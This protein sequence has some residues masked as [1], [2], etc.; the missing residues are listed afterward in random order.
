MDFKIEP[1]Y[2][3]AYST[4]K[5]D[6]TPAGNAAML[7]A[8]EPDIDKAI[9]THVGK[10]NPLLKSQARKLAI[11]GMQ[12][13]DPSQSRIRTHLYNQLQ[14]LKRYNAKQQQTIKVPERIMLDRRGIDLLTTEL[15]DELGREPTDQELTDR[16]GLSDKRLKRIR[17][18][19]P[20]VNEGYLSSLP[21][22]GVSPGVQ[23]DSDIWMQAVYE[24]LGS[25]DQK[26]FEWTLGYNGRRPLSNQE[27]AKKLKLSPGA[28]SQ[29][30]VG[31]QRLIEM[32]ADLSPF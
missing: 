14:G 26:I 18:Y 31:I 21:G 29:R 17:E 16:S 28:I 19:Q 20:S 1:E 30:K 9:K 27:I 4:W 2:Q 13:Y 5:A 7:R 23:S 25:I 11:T 32:E 6:P 3:E 12:S 24:D 15:E 22:E 8:L 10:S